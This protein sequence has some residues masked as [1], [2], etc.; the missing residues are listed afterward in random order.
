[1]SRRDLVS[2][3]TFCEQTVH[4]PSHDFVLETEINE[5]GI[6]KDSMRG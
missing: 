5:I 6:D 4:R 3:L 2:S 1:M